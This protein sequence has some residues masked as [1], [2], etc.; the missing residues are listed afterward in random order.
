MP[1]DQQ[2]GCKLCKSKQNRIF[3]VSERMLGL[4]GKFSYSECLN[5]G[6]LQ[7]T[8][9]INDFSIFYPNQYYSFSD[10]RYSNS[11]VKFLKK[12]RMRIFL[13]TGWK[14]SAPRYGYW[15]KRIN[16]GFTHR[17]ADVGCGNGQL[18]Y[19]LSISGF[20]D[21]HGFDPYIIESKVISPNL[22]L[23][24]QRIEDSDKQFDFIFMHHSFEHMEDPEA[25]LRSCFEK[26]NSEGILLV[27]CPVADAEIWKTKGPLWV[28]LDAPRHILIPTVE[29]M[30][31]V[32]ERVGFKLSEVAFDST[33]FQFWGTQLY[34][35]GEKLD[36]KLI[37]KY[38][39]NAQR[40]VLIKKASQFNREC[41]GDQACFYLVK[42]Q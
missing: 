38:I 31:K 37:G 27:R 14:L 8:E 16:P 21:L 26:L 3:H 7:L 30:K 35:N 4:G 40:K 6:S 2:K 36:E 17:I 34:E 28:Q 41:K 18:L 9:E 10:L 39:S 22:R 23:W 13:W 11:L 29:G 1:I 20:K 15:L 12:L 33:D 5:C 19:E 24:K 32:A 25:V 42:N